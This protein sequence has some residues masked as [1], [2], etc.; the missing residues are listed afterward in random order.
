MAN[1]V[2]TE[3][4]E[5]VR[6]FAIQFGL[7]LIEVEYA[8][9]VDGMNLTIY[10]DKD[11]GVSLDDCERLHRAIDEPLDVLDPT[12]GAAYTLNVSSL[13]L[14]WPLKT[15]R[16]YRKNLGK[17]ITVKLYT[18]DEDGKKKYDGVLKEFDAESFVIG[19]EKKK[20][21]RFERAK[22]AHVEPLIRF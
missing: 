4:M 16:D 1:R 5:L 21:L 11:G 18:K 10:I 14:D 12:N 19:T 22:V 17:E 13:G 3:V 6:P 2:E 20:E 15:D 7:E 8:K 9:K